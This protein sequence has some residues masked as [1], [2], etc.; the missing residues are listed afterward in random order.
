M[1]FINTAKSKPAIR[2]S[3]FSREQQLNC[4]EGNSFSDENITD[5]FAFFRGLKSDII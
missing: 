1:K 5:N 2:D 3:I 4:F